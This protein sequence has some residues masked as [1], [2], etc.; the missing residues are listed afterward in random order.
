MKAKKT[1]NITDRVPAH[2]MPPDVVAKEFAVD[3]ANGLSDAEAEQRLEKYGPNTIT[4]KEQVSPFIIFLRQFKGPFVLLLFLA[5]GLSFWFQEWLDATA[6]LVVI[7]INALIGFFMEYKAER[8]ME[9]LKR[10]TQL[11]AKVVRGGTLVEISSDKIVPGDV[12]MA[13]AGDV[14]LADARV[15]KCSQLEVDESA[16]TGESLTV[17][18]DVD[19]VGAGTPLAD[20]KNMLFKGTFIT[21]GNVYAIV[22]GTGMQTEL[23]NIAEMVQSADQAAT[24]L[25]KKITQFSKKIL[26]LT[27]ALIALLFIAGLIRG[28]EIMEL[29]HTSI[30]LAVAAIPEGLPIVTT[31]ALA[32][33]MIRMARHK[34]I[35]KKLAAVE[36][37]GGTNVICTDKTGTL[38]QNKI[39]VHDV[40]ITEGWVQLSQDIAAR[41]SNVINGEAAILNSE[42]FGI[43]KLVSVLCNTADINHHKGELRETGDPLETGLLKFAYAHGVDVL[44]TRT[45]YPKTGEEPFTSETRI[46]ATRHPGEHG[47]LIVA[48]GAVEELMKRCKY[49]RAADGSLV[50]L[51]ESLRNDWIK[52]ADDLAAAGSRVIAMAYKET[53]NDAEALSDNLVF[54]ALIGLLDPPRED[55]FAAIEEC[56]TAGISVIMITG[57]HPA[58]A[59]T[60]G[61]KLGLQ[62]DEEGDV[63]HGKSMSDYEK[64]SSEEKKKWLN[65]KIFARV[66]PKQKLDLITVL[67]ENKATV[68]MT[69]D[70]VNDAPALKKADIG[71]AMGQRGTQV[72]QDAADII[73]KDDSFSAIVIAI[74]SGRIIYENIRK[75][76]MYLLSCNLSE[77]FI[78]TFSIFLNLPFA[79]LPIQILYINLVT[80]VLPALA[81][82]VT[83]GSDQIMKQPPRNS[84]EKLIDRKRWISIFVYSSVIGISCIGAVVFANYTIHPGKEWNQQLCNNMLFITLILAQL[85][86]VLNMTLDNSMPIYKTDVFRNIYVWIAIAICLL[87][88]FGI[89]F[90]QPIATVLSLSKLT[91]A[92]LSVMLAFSL[93]SLIIIRILKRIKIIL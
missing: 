31:L 12:L 42:N 14:I 67:Q 8:S 57:D 39:E 78:I 23:G 59:R 70:G 22:T 88:T 6:I 41:K 53:T 48:K 51:S 91:F 40:I 43:V 10:L 86:N 20:R 64:L 36:T 63:I 76:I 87:L 11:N 18:K 38:T 69:G 61:E 5:A 7:F 58:T 33:G 19:P 90:I 45:Q 29:L 77:L 17:A 37:L 50:S 16:L 49:I 24:P 54:I 89:Y 81:L 27:V 65:A 1:H 93:L 32:Q 85:W 30:A 80:D 71:I 25:E 92:D 75:F 34:V 3:P 66:T 68:G 79:L 2:A 21:K 56:K 72:A 9:S 26:W 13:E 52:R 28:D 82:G 15:Y 83:E 4:E 47:N 62:S 74:K 60:I 84:S 46:M 55:V 73:L 35:I 44:A